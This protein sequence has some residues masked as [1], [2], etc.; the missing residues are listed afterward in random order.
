MEEAK[1]AAINIFVTHF[2]PL[3]AQVVVREVP[4]SSPRFISPGFRGKCTLVFQRLSYRE[5]HP[6]VDVITVGTAAGAALVCCCYNRRWVL[7]QAQ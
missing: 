3:A 4:L 6:A 5:V 7:F 1:H 2:S